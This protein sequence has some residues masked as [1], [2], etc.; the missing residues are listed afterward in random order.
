MTCIRAV[1]LVMSVLAVHCGRPP[2]VPPVEVE[3]TVVDAGMETDA[4]VA[5]DAG[6]LTLTPTAAEATCIADG[7]QLAARVVS[8]QTRK[9]LFRT[10]SGPWSKGALL[11]LH[12]GGG[13]ADHFC[14]G[15][16]LVQPQIAFA[17]EAVQRGFAVFVL[18]ATTNVVTDAQ[19]RPCGK[20]FDFS[21]LPRANLDLP[22]VEWVAKEL[23]PRSRPANSRA[24]L[25]IAGHS[26]GGY[27]TTRAATHFDDVFTAFA[28]VATADPYGTDTV[29]DPALSPRESAVGIL[30]DRETRK[31]IIEDDACLSASYPNESPWSTTRPAKKPTAKQFHDEKDGIVDLSCMRKLSTQLQANGY[32]MR[33]PLVLQTPGP[34]NVLLHL[35]RASYNAPLLDFFGS[36][37]P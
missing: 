23:V 12:G 1:G 37:T 31:E 6:V 24:E 10:P 36:F 27:M 13:Q 11:V 35:W 25:F 5:A 28:L 18:D 7:W 30:V 33:A 20:R 3:Q 2:E 19:G 17:R 4:G 32:P 22:Y 26:T 9:V 15:G 14:T 21:V 8:G 16:M 29:C 34:K